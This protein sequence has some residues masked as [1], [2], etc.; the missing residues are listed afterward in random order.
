MSFHFLCFIERLYKL[1]N[2]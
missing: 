1:L 2:I